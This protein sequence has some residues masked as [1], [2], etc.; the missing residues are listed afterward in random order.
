MSA[1]VGFRLAF[2]AEQVTTVWPPTGIA[3]AAL[4]LW[5]LRLWPAIWG[6]AFI[7]NATIE[8]PLWSAAS[9][10]TGNTLEAVAAAWLLSR[11][12]FNPA[13]D[14]TRDTLAFITIGVVATTAISATIGT[15]SLC[16]SDLESWDRFWT[17]WT[18]WWLGDALGSL[19]VAPVLLT[20]LRS[21]V[22]LTRSQQLETGAWVAASVA[23]TALVFGRTWSTMSGHFP[24]A[25]T[26]FP[27]VIAAAV[28]LGH[29]AT[30]LVTLGTIAVT[31]SN[32]VRGIGPFTT[33]AVHDALI[34]AQVFTGV[35]AGSGLLLAA[36]VME[37]R[38]IEQRRAA[39]YGVG[40]ALAT[41]QDLTEA[42]P[43]VL[44]VIGTNLDWQV[45]ALWTVDSGASRIRC[46]SVWYPAD[47]SAPKF[48][49][50]TKEMQF[51]SGVGLPGRV[52]ATGRPAWI[53]DV[54]EDPNFPRA[55][56][57]RREGLHGAFGFPIL[58]GDK[59]V[60][61][62]EFFNRTVEAPDTDLLATMAA[63]G[64]EIGQFISRKHTEAVAA[65]TQ[66][67][68]R[69]ILETAMD[70]ILTMD[71]RGVITE[72]NPAAERMFGHHRDDAVGRE[73]AA[74]IIPASL[75]ERH[76][77]GLRTYL[78]TG[79]GPFIDRRIDTTAV[80]ADGE[81]FPV[82]VSITK[83][84]TDPPMFTGFVRDVTDR[85]AAELERGQLLER[86]LSARRQA[87]SANRA[88]DIFLATLSH[89]LRTPLNAIVG[90]TRMLV[91][92]T[93]DQPTATRAL[94]IIDRNAHAQLQLVEDILDVSRI[95]TG[96]LSLDLQPV[97]L[98]II[99]GAVL[100]SFRP[101]A[102]A[103]NIRV[104]STLSAAARLTA[105]DPKRLQQ[106][107]WN[108]V[109]NALKFTAQGGH[110]SVDVLECGASS[111]CV[112]VTDD[113]VGIAPDFLPRLFERFTQA[114][115]ST[116]RQH[117]GLGLGL[118][119]TRHLVELHGGTVRAESKG[120]GMGSTF[121]VEL[122]KLAVELPVDVTASVKDGRSRQTP[123]TGCHVL[124]VEDEADARD[125][126]AT[127]LSKAGAA[128]ELATSV[129]EALAA[130]D[131]TPPDVLLSDIGL[132]GQDG[133]ELIQ[134][135]RTR[136][137]VRRMHVPAAAITAYAREED[138]R[139][140]LAAGFDRYVPKPI[141]SGVVEVVR[142]LWKDRVSTA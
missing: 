123:L 35:L 12:G 108:L 32:T 40:E 28:R 91:D 16:A 92:G 93:L 18:E 110:I 112:N 142:R 11:W 135:V 65:E 90:W 102:E 79:K 141:D 31:L 124:V 117:G 26:I 24:L 101:A 1:R 139:R 69:A 109:S 59:V 63:I 10:A 88:K 37:R 118:A 98:G 127:I 20:L 45:G 134:Q 22:R 95:V 133:F 43:R 34:Q 38:V 82:E 62:V 44:A 122:P 115:S 103:K 83:V 73:L 36:A 130:V 21:G 107:V 140:A 99:V 131:R 68:T 136:D 119:I 132:V 2:V 54:V 46:I 113:G 137:A 29:P 78:E 9:I 70:A 51:A 67:R 121:T 87:E 57:A 97:D 55:P 94:Q 96:K 138:R 48:V 76:R 111:V 56:V 77:Q 47:T 129:E 25:F 3:Q 81:E 106:V 15:T 5:G 120:P 60:G 42:A 74:L 27:F 114:D 50:L 61:I 89:E 126:L 4:L 41:S 128:V 75:Q 80:R 116:T 19:V 58:I 86:E 8:G 66:I 85:Q 14:R 53:R 49:Q 7:V 64:G 71:Q 6:A 84:A 100:E 125:L 23:A 52:W 17:I 72:F 39:A 105:G 33:S 104:R 30:A 13:L